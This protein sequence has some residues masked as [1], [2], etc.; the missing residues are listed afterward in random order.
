MVYFAIESCGFGCV[1]IPWIRASRILCSIAPRAHLLKPVTQKTLP[2]CKMN[3]IAL[4]ALARYKPAKL[5]Y[6][7]SPT[8]KEAAVVA[9]KVKFL[10]SSSSSSSSSFSLKSC[11]THTEKGSEGKFATAAARTLISSASF[12]LSVAM[13]AAP[14]RESTSDRDDADGPWKMSRQASKKKKNS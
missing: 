14:F 2:L 3:S 10:L 11:Q 8:E 7:S 13:P 1:F 12:R 9:Q 5:R 6:S 4:I